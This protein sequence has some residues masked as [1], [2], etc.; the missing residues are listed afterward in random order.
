MG[1]RMIGI[2]SCLCFL[3]GGFGFPDGLRSA[4]TKA[5]HIEIFLLCPLSFD[6]IIKVMEKHVHQI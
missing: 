4:I 3:E 2:P 1:S 5:F 6:I